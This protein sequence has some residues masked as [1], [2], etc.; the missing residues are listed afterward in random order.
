MKRSQTIAIVLL[1]LG[2]IYGYA[3]A[4]RNQNP[5]Y[6]VGGKPRDESQ[7]E[8]AWRWRPSPLCLPSYLLCTVPKNG[9]AI[10]ETR[11][12]FLFKSEA[13]KQL[14]I[15]TSTAL[16]LGLGLLGAFIALALGALARRKKQKHP[17][18]PAQPT[19]PATPRPSPSNDPGGEQQ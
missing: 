9:F 11:S 7:R 3:S 14:Y 18:E 4:L 1:I 17:I 19:N 5:Y 12:G 2:A 13:K 6:A 8:L 16:G 15:R 10:S